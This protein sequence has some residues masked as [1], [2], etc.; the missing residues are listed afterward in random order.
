MVHADD[1]GLVLPPP[2]API[3][4]SICTLLANK[5]DKIGPAAQ[6]MAYQLKNYRVSLDESDKGIGFKLAQKNEIE[7]IL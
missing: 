7:G 2:I 3:Q 1:R 5:N 4:I 6:T